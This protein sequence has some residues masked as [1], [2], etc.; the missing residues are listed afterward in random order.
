M[1]IQTLV[2]SL[3]LQ[4]AEAP[5]G[6]EDGL[7]TTEFGPDS[8][9]VEGFGGNA[10]VIATP[11]GV[12]LVDSMMRPASEALLALVEERFDEPPR[13]LV[14]THFH[15]DHSRG[16]DVFNAAGVLTI[17]H[18]AMRARIT[19]RRYSELSERWI[20]ARPDAGWPAASYSHA[21]TLHWGEERITLQH[22]PAAHTAGDTVVRAEAA[23]V[24]STGDI[25][26][27][28]VWPIIDTHAGG[29]VDGTVEALG[30]IIAMADDDTRIAPGHGP[31]AGRADV[32]AFRDRLV[33]FREITLAA[34]ADGVSREAFVASDPFQA[35]AP[36]WRAWFIHSG[37][38]AGIYYDDLRDSTA[39]D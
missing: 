1:I 27:H 10:T 16:N 19:V 4:A 7:E 25:F 31:A 12:V 37:D 18:D 24:I 14:N 3:A 29:G 21:L 39:S 8:F 6:P 32:I 17:A 20:E 28:G 36:D 30:A 23:N 2:A 13:L 11:Q 5:P 33:R 22:L 35:V 38:L 34:L 15:G 9:M 26:V